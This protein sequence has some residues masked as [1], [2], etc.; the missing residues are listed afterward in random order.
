MKAA[1]WRRAVTASVLPGLPGDWLATGY[2]LVQEPIGPLARAIVRSPSSYG[3]GYYLYVT[4]QPLFVEMETW[5][6]NMPVQLGHA[7]GRGRWPGFDRLDQS[8]GAFDALAELIR[9]EALPYLAEHGTPAGF[10]ELCRA[11]AAAMPGFGRVYLQRQQAATEVLLGDHAAAAATLAEI[12]ATAA[13]VPG[14]PPWL[15]ELA[16]E[17]G[18]F[19]RMLADDPGSVEDRLAATG[20]HMR[21]RLG[22]PGGA[23]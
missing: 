8:A 20:T 15:A 7:A 2:A 11:E 10:R 3:T 17:A 9:E 5:Q 4:V 22:L 16:A 1:V 12:G 21:Q 6:A 14:A 13:A 23:A 18:E 19:R